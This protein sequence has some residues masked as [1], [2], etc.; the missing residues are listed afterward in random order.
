MVFQNRTVQAQEVEFEVR[1]PEV[2]NTYVLEDGTTL[3]VKL[4]ML[5]VIRLD[6]YAPDGTPVYQFNAQQIV[7]AQV[8]DALK[9]KVN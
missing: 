7:A 8:P 2:W 9:K 4:V 3:K 1:S 5:N 6:E